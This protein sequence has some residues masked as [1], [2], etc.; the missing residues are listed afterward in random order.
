MNS[1]PAPSA[2]ARRWRRILVLPPLALGAALL[3]VQIR[4]ERGPEAPVAGERVTAVEV[5]RLAPTTVV[6]RAVGYGTVQPARTY[7]ATAEIAGRIVERHPRL[8]RGRLLPAGTLIATVDRADYDLAR[9]RVA[10]EIQRLEAQIRQLEVRRENLE[11]SLEIEERGARLAADDLERQRRLFERGNTSA[12]AVDQA[13]TTLLNRR[14]QVQNVRASLAEIEPE[15]AVREADLAVRRTELRQAE[16]ELERTE[17]YLPVD[18]PVADVDVEVGE[19]VQR[20]AV[21]ATFDD[22]AE[23]EIDAQFAL[24]QIRPLIPADMAV[25]ALDL[26]TLRDLPERLG[27]EATVRLRERDLDIVWQARFDRPSDRI[28]AQTRTLG[29]IIAVDEPYASARPGER[30]PLTK[31]MF[32]EVVIEG[33]PKT[34]RLVVPVAAVHDRGSAPTVHVVDADDRL[35]IRR[36]RIESIAGDRAIIADGLAAGDR[37]VVTE[38]QPAVEGMR[39]APSERTA[40]AATRVSEAA[41]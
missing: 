39:L 17:L 31:G 1:S 40:P 18:E 22:I 20:G 9:A 34:E 24:S 41:S 16:L 15:I 33:R 19:Y 4:A 25:P 11:R 28:D 14:D 6:P 37:V 38:I 27:L 29:L 13:E 3:V 12:A 30:P 23:A 21:V 35:A 10:A 36:V 32:V 7:R 5:V 2:P 26:E 8:E